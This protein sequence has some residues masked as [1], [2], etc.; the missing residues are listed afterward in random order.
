M[1]YRLICSVLLS[2]MYTLTNWAL[3]QKIRFSAFFTAITNN[4]AHFFFCS[5]DQR[6]KLTETL[7]MGLGVAFILLD[8]VNNG[9]YWRYTLSARYATC[10]KKSNFDTHCTCA[11]H[12]QHDIATVSILPLFHT[13]WETHENTNI[14]SSKTIGP[15]MLEFLPMFITD[16]VLPALNVWTAQSSLA[17]KL[18]CCFAPLYSLWLLSPSLL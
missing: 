14:Y 10:A 5:I 9:N 13:R 4:I 8:W 15:T 7:D 1:S 12:I 2:T 18:L 3:H 17:H 16:W 11:K 6:E